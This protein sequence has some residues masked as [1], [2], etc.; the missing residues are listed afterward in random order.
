MLS[1]LE[2]FFSRL[3]DSGYAYLLLEPL[4]LYGI[5][6]GVTFYCIGQYMSQPK[7]RTAALIV[8]GLCSLSIVPCLSLRH[9]AQ[10]R[11]FE[12][13]PADKLQIN[14]QYKR[15][16]DTKWIYYALAIAAGLALISGGK[17]ASFS[18]IAIIAGGVLVIFFSAWMHMK[19][20]EIY[21]PNIIQRAV[22]VK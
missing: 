7:C 10:A 18:N 15:R 4:L 1:N 17:L 11:E 14:E 9:R 12:K 2:I 3:R 13:R 20:A 21:H 19:E 16:V 22:P 8:I 5:F 6:F